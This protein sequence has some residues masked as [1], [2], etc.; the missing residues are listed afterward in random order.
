MRILSR[1]LVA[2]FLAFFAVSSIVIL[3]VISIA[4]VMTHIDD[5]LEEGGWLRGTAGYLALKIP[6]V[7][8]RS[9]I[10]IAT[11]AAAFACVGLAARWRETLAMKAAGISPLRASVPLV[12]LTALLALATLAINE[13]LVIGAMRTWERREHGDH[14]A[15]AFRRGSFWYHRGHTI[16]NI[17]YGDPATNT[18]R[19]VS[20]FELDDRGRLIKSIRAARVQIEDD[21]HWRL[22]DVTIRAF[23]PAKPLAPPG[24]ERLDETVLEIAD[25]AD[26]ALREAD[27]S[28]L[29][30]PDLWEYIQARSR[31]GEDVARA[32]GL[33]HG[34]LADPLTVLLFAG[35]AIPL[36]MRVEESH[37]L[38]VPA[39]MGVLMIAVFGF[40]RTLG[41]VLV[42]EGVTPPA[43][44]AWG[45]LAAF[46]IF[47]AWRFSRIPR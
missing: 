1:Y 5:V 8:L 13:T 26:S 21:R 42:D 41:E 29:S 20:L 38:A 40:T 6:A 31:E 47:V 2:R 19:G 27:A 10:P 11:F 12:L 39:L 30:L 24:F 15:I 18:W 43:A 14:G 34:R 44:T 45:V 28:L 17:R 4:E 9:L 36:G 35:L 3:V 7:Y 32:T 22:I 46:G 23:D 16:Y 25:E 37:S 33:F